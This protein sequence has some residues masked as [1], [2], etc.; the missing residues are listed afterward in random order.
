MDCQEKLHY[1]A[2]FMPLNA[3]HYNASVALLIIDIQETF[4]GTVTNGDT[5]LQ[6]CCFAAEAAK[7]FEVPVFLT[8]QVPKK[9]GPIHPHLA[10]IARES[11]VFAKSTFSA[12]QLLRLKKE[13]QDAS[14]QHLLIAG[15]ETPVCIFQTVMDALRQNFR[16]TLLSDCIACRRREDGEAV[17][18]YLGS[19]PNVFRLPSEAVFYS[20]LG[21]AN[22]PQFR[23]FTKLVKKYG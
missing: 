22:N 5:L 21:G 9:L 4:L 2:A 19:Q 12:M 14:I 8:E 17:M 20:I 16:L 7:L 10:A 13:L 23:S 1:K 15:L 3:E 6:R 11:P 18:A